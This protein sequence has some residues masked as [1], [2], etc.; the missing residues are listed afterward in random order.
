MNGFS[1]S[2]IDCRF[3]KRIRRAGWL[4]GQWVEYRPPGPEGEAW[5]M[6]HGVVEVLGLELVPWQPTVP[7][8]LANDWSTLP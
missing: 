4:E 2:R 8:L 3:G 7:D 1:K 5:L 6:F